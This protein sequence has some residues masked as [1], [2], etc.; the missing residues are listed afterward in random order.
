MTL[1]PF[2]YLTRRFVFTCIVIFFFIGCDD[3]KYSNAKTDETPVLKKLDRG[4]FVL[5]FENSDAMSPIIKAELNNDG[6]FNNMIKKLNE[7]LILPFNIPITFRNIGEY[8]AYYDP[9]ERSITFGYEFVTLFK[10][11]YSRE[12]TNDAD[13]W[14]ATRNTTYFFLL[15]EIGHALVHIYKIPSAANQ[16]DLADNFAIYMM[17]GDEIS[18]DALLHGASYFQIMT[19]YLADMK[20]SDLPVLDEH[21]LDPQRYF[22]LLCKVYASNPVRYNY[23]ITQGYLDQEKTGLAKDA[24]E[25][26]NAAWERDLKEWVK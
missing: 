21:G 19:R 7:Q 5:R 20:L 4:D 24:Y 17:T 11:L 6:L 3:N 1:P 8:N 25:S 10:N 23:L 13:V 16:E 22:N 14:N 15:H 9:E 18:T 12:Y 26:N 2:T